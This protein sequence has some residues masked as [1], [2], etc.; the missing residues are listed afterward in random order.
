MN[1]HRQVNGFIWSFLLFV[2]IAV[3]CEIKV[4]AIF[5]SSHTREFFKMGERSAKKTKLRKP[6]FC[7]WLA[8]ALPC[9]DHYLKLRRES[10]EV[11]FYNI[12]YVGRYI[13]RR[14]W[15]TLSSTWQRIG[16]LTFRLF[17]FFHHPFL[18]VCI[19]FN[20]SYVVGCF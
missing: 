4:K 19:F 20:N 3:Q 2:S 1:C 10:R 6:D 17:Q 11:V 16:V 18:F 5:I 8:F 9:S 7:L 13:N 12:Q 14:F 15:G